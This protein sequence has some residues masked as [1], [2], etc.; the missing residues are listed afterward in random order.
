MTNT[1]INT[2]LFDLAQMK[3]KVY[4]KKL[5]VTSGEFIGVSIPA[6]RILAKELIKGDYQEFLRTSTHHYYEESMLV[7]LVIAYCKEPINEK[8]K[9][10][11]LFLPKIDNWAVND[12]VAMTIKFKASEMQIGHDFIMK[13]IYSE[14]EYEKR[15][16]IVLLFTNFSTLLYIDSTTKLL[17]ALPVNHYYTQMAA[18]WGLSN[19]IAKHPDI[20][21]PIFENATTDTFT[22]NK[23]IQKS[24]ESFRVSKENKEYLL[25]LKRE[26]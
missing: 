7:G 1:E 16:A 26:K 2:R 14:K 8:L 15:F 20:A 18:A 4:S 9:L 21:I 22:F 25:T 10:L 19:C 24:R 6:I 12:S 13:Y 23:A 5:I 11:E 3:Y 17:A